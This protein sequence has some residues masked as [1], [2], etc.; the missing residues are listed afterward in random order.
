MKKSFLKFAMGFLAI[1]SLTY[2]ACKPED[3][4]DEEELITKV[5][6]TLVDAAGKSSTFIW[7][8]PDGTAGAQKPTIDNVSLVANS[9]YT[10]SVKV[11]NASVKPVEDITTEIQKESNDHLFVY[12]FDKSNLTVEITDKD[13]NGKALGLA[14]KM[15]TKAVGD[16][17]LRIVLK[18]KPTDKGNATNPGGETDFDVEFAVSVK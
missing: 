10:A 16:G 12:T 2:T 4:P 15:T 11:E 3:T 13:G 5:S 6:L 7:N 9:V 1:F 14:T 8:D 18:H 17:K